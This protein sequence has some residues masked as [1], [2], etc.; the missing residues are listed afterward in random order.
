MECGINRT[1]ANYHKNRDPEFAAMW[2]DAIE[3]SLDMIEDSLRTRCI[4]GVD[5]PVFYKG[6]ECGKIKRYSDSNGQFLL[7]GNRDKYNRVIQETTHKIDI[8]SIASTLKELAANKERPAI[9]PVD[10]EVISDESKD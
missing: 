5:E 2:E 6:T 4:D 10:V 3:H 7:K 9:E 8:S 1:T